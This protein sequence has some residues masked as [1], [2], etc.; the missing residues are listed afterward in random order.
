MQILGEEKAH[1]VDQVQ[2]KIVNL[3][4]SSKAWRRLNREL[5]NG[6]IKLF[7]VPT[8]RRIFVSKSDLLLKLLTRHSLEYR[9]LSL[10]I[11]SFS[12]SVHDAVY[13]RS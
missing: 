4:K 7:S 12:I 8:F 11:S 3:A 2:Q 1:Y 9:M 5:V 13:S 6:K 10:G